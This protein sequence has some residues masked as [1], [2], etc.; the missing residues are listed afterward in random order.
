VKISLLLEGILDGVDNLGEVLKVQQ[1][2]IFFHLAI[3]IHLHQVGLVDVDHYREEGKRVA[4]V[5]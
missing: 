1:D 4:K 3:L 2:L 5:F